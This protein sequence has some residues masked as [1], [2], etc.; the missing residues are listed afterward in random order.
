VGPDALPGRDRERGHPIE[1][2]FERVEIE[3]QRGRVD[4]IERRARL[5]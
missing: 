4:A 3:D 2:A 5:R 1:V